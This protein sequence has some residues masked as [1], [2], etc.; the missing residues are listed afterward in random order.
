MTAPRD[1]G[2]EAVQRIARL[3]Q[4]EEDRVKWTTQ[5]FDWWPGRF[6]VSVAS[7]RQQD[8]EAWR[9][10]VSTDFLRNVPL[11][12]F[13]CRKAILMMSRFAPSYAWVFTPPEVQEQYELHADGVLKFRS[14]VY[15]REDTAGWLPEF[16]GRMAILQPIQAEVQAEAAVSLVKGQV[17]CS[18]PRDNASPDYRDEVLDV[19]GAIYVPAGREESRWIGTDEFMTTASRFGR[20]DMCFGMGD[21]TG[22]TLETPIG[23]SSALI[24][25]RTDVPHPALGKGLLSSVQLPFWQDETKTVEDAM[26]YNFFQSVFWSDVPQLGSWHPRQVADGQYCAASGT[27]YPNALYMEWL[28]T[29]AALWQLGLARWIKER[30]HTDLVDQTMAQ[31]L[32]SRMD[33]S[34]PDQ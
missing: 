33:R 32:E 3:W 4:V 20:Q 18:L 26:W 10:S 13:E 24:R 29:N 12:D 9:L 14:S 21:A 22:L 7:H 1:L 28:A 8:E 30:F 11:Q 25:L 15:L 6:R 27:F 2:D 31:I 5:G 34:R 23:T 17:D 16:L 19:A